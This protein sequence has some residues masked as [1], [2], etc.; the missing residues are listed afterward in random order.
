[1]KV[2][3]STVLVVVLVACN[4]PIQPPES[5]PGEVLIPAG[6]SWRHAVD[7]PSGVDWV[8]PD[9]D[10]R[11]WAEGS[12]P[13]G[14]STAGLRTQT[15]DPTV[16]E[17][18]SMAV[19]FRTSFELPE[20]HGIEGLTVHYLRDDGLRLWLNGVEMLRHDL[21]AGDIN[22]T[23]MA[24]RA[25]HGSEEATWERL[26]LPAGALRPGS[27]QIAAAVHQVSVSGGDLIFDLELRGF[28]RSDDPVLTRGPY[29]QQTS[30]TRS[31]VRWQTAAPARG[32]V[33][34]GGSPGEV[35][36]RIPEKAVR[37]DHEVEVVGLPE[38]PAYYSVGVESVG[39]EGTAGVEDVLLAGGDAAHQIAR[40][41]A[42]VRFWIT[43]DQGGA[44]EGTRQVRDGML[45]AAGPRPPSAWLTLGDNAD[46]SG[47]EAEFQAAVFDTF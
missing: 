46:P 32:W 9:F 35:I 11:G 23:S 26:A 45:I 10:D 18:P 36:R 15:A 12:G 40:P 39:A 22:R 41:G 38:G 3:A 30:S 34:V 5:G 4:P 31:I 17:P 19:L 7:L 21:R 47:T 43:G 24:A 20:A 44:D 42:A 8:A 13:L 25:V 37:R 29:L 6:S 16:L 33:E 28:R 27:N 14:R 2:L 1:M